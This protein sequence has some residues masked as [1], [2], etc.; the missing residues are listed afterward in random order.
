LA[1]AGLLP[2]ITGNT[3]TNSDTSPIH[4]GANIVGQIVTGNSFSEMTSSGRIEVMA[5]Q[6]S[7][8]ALWKQLPASY[9]IL[10]STSVYKDTSNP[11]TLTIEPG[12]TLKFAANAGLFIGNGTGGGALIAQGTPS[13]RITFTRS[14]T[15]G[16]WGGIQFYDGTVDSTTRIEYTD[17]Q[18]STGLYVAQASPVIKNTTITDAAGNGLNISSANPTL[19]NVTVNCNGSYGIHLSGSSP[20]II[21]GSLTNI[22]ISGHGI[23][24]SGCSASVGNGLLDR[25]I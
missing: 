16:T 25:L 4:V 10:G 23:Y 11:V 5:E 22:N 18:Y 17:I 3:F 20:T 14:G 9:V 13:A 21:G 7:R 19:E 15:S 8:N 24:G 1:S 12:A 6:I 2:T